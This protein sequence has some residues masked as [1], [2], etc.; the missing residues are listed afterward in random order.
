MKLTNMKHYKVLKMCRSSWHRYQSYPSTNQ[1][2]RQSNWCQHHSTARWAPCNGKAD[3]QSLYWKITE[4]ATNF[5]YPTKLFR[6]RTS[7]HIHHNISC[8]PP[9]SLTERTTT[10]G[11]RTVRLSNT[12][13]I[14][15]CTNHCPRRRE[16]LCSV[17]WVDSPW[18]S[19]VHQRDVALL[20][21]FDL[22][23]HWLLA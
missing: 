18:L 10:W 7:E 12:I 3:Q 16:T 19:T 9:L 13:S 21:E 14:I 23:T 15:S 2:N 17:K 20:N 8:C 22:T 1:K 4:M 6:A 11:S 5:F